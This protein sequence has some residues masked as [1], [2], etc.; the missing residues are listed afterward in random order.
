[1]KLFTP[2]E[3]TRT[4]PLV[5]QI[6][7]DI[8]SVG[9]NAKILASRIPMQEGDKERLEN[10]KLEISELITELEE[11]GCLYKD[12]NFEIG[13]VDFPA[14]IEGEQVLLCWRSDENTITY[15]HR[16]QDGYSGRQ[17]IPDKYF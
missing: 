11:L 3:A 7:D 9:K 5:R 12:W 8:L 14:I 2:K 13:L 10:L 4:L 16:M 1:M 15:Y 17:K 6:V